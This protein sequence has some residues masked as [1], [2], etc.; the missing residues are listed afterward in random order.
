MKFFLIHWSYYRLGGL[1]LSEAVDVLPG[2]VIFQ[3]IINGIGGNLVSV[4]ASRI[5]TTLHQTSIMGLIPPYTKVFVSPFKALVKGGNYIPIWLFIPV[6]IGKM[7]KSYMRNV[8]L[9][10]SIRQNCKTTYCYGNLG[11]NCI[12]ICR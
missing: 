5:S 4:Q 2:F 3:P 11:R 6:F 1:I 7:T 9:C 8:L 12:Y 10:S